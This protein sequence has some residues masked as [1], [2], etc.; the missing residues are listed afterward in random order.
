M[1]SSCWVGWVP[2]SLCSSAG[3]GTRLAAANLRPRLRSLAYEE[4]A[5]KLVHGILPTGR[6]ALPKGLSVADP[7]GLLEAVAR[8]DVD[9]RPR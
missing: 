5:T 6:P 2:M 1:R 8:R 4:V 9:L 3:P 7:E